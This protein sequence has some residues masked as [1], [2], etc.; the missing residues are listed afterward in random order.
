VGFFTGAPAVE[1]TEGLLAE[2]AALSWDSKVPSYNQRRQVHSNP[3]PHT[4]PP[5]THAHTSCN[6]PP[7]L[8]AHSSMDLTYAHVRMSGQ[9]NLPTV[10]PTPP[11]TPSPVPTSHVPHTVQALMRGVVKHKR[12]RHNLCYADFAQEPDYAAG[13]GRVVP[14]TSLPWTSRLREGIGRVV[15]AT[16]GWSHDAHCSG[17]GFSNWVVARGLGIQGGG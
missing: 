6:T 11:P 9:G 4:P 10:H 17:L 8:C 15:G 1:A 13:K 5:N 12:A 14:F 2:Q 7:A 3:H 16:L